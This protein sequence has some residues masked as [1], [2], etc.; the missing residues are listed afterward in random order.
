MTGNKG[1]W[2][3]LYALFKLAADGRLYAADEN[4]EK[5][6]TIYYDILK[7]IRKQKNDNLHYI[8]DGNIRFL[9]EKTGTEIAIVPISEFEKNAEILL[10]AVKLVKSK[11]GSF[12]IPGIGTF[13]S[14]IK[15]NATKAKSTDKADITLVVHDATTGSR[16]TLGF[17]IKSQ[18]GSPSTLFNASCATNLVFDLT[19]H[20][21]SEEEKETFHDFKFFKDKFKYLDSLG[22]GLKFVGAD[23]DVFAS[24]LML[25]DTF[26]PQILS[27]MTENYFRGKAVKVSDLTDL[28]TVENICCVTA[29][30][31][32]TFYTFKIK[33]LL[34]DIALGMTPASP[35]NGRYDA[36]G[37]YIIV[38]DSGDILCYHIYNRNEFREYLY[39]N[40]RFDTPSQ[41]KHKFG[42]IENI[43]EGQ[44]LKLNMQIRFLK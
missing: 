32:K 12:E 16:P 5:I 1:E 11:N 37:G 21:L 23:N 17:S 29:S 43:G 31:A 27:S 34:T 20:F 25:V 22:T 10:S 18:L 3:E 9:S 8:R 2:S 35:W 6:N 14:K 44:K 28:C 26:M 24:N 4:T 13:I 39:K 41:T 33:E 36:T 42:T 40:T 30:A 38:K 15:C 19:G 7:I